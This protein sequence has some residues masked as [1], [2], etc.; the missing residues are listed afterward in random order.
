MVAVAKGLRLSTAVWGAMV[1]HVRGVYPQEGCGLLAGAAGRATA[2]I[3]VPNQLASPV[4]FRMEPAAQIRAMLAIEQSGAELVAIYHS[5][6]HTA[7]YPSPSDVAAGGDYPEA[8][9]FIISL[10]GEKEGGEPTAGFFR[11]A[12]GQVVALEWAL[13]DGE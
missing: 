10:A 4:A 6:P 7:A 3:P 5:H 11:I 13:D 9:L 2:V 8:G 12:Q 1:A